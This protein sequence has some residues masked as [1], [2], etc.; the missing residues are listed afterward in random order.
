MINQK[1]IKILLPLV[2]LF[3][4]ASVQAKIILYSAPWCGFCVKMEEYLKSN[5]IRFVKIDIDKV[6]SAKQEVVTKSKQAGIPVLDWNGEIIVGFGNTEKK[7]IDRLAAG[8]TPI[9]GRF[10]PKM[11][12]ESNQ[13]LPNIPSLTLNDRFTSIKNIAE[14]MRIAAAD[15]CSV[16]IVEKFYSA[17]IAKLTYEH[18]FTPLFQIECKKLLMPDSPDELIVTCQHL[19]AAKYSQAVKEFRDCRLKNVRASVAVQNALKAIIASDA[20][21]PNFNQ[22]A[23]YL[24]IWSCA[25]IDYV[26][27]NRLQPDPSANISRDGETAQTAAQLLEKISCEM[28]NPKLPEDPNAVTASN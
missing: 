7:E 22:Q 10:I 3:V 9:Q 28:Q 12:V 23:E 6:R 19:A 27:G 17:Q 18:C 5:N 15:S 1:I 24:K 13:P 14:T 11:V 20:A 4:S 25:A 2:I 21:D 8:G 26:S 16:N